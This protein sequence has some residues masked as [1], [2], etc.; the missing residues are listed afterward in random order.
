VHR[1][2]VGVLA[3]HRDAARALAEIAQRGE[4]AG[5]VGAVRARLD[6]DRALEREPREVRAQVGDG[7]VERSVFPF[8]IERKTLGRAE[9][10][11][12]AVAAELQ[13]LMSLTVRYLSPV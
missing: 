13:S 7:G 1:L 9:D 4:R 2:E 3:D 6:D 8:T 5:V 11:D 10:M 12:V